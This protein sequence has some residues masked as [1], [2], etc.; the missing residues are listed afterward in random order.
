M[1]LG[2][3]AVERD[4]ELIQK[5]QRRMQKNLIEPS[6]GYSRFELSDFESASKRYFLSAFTKKKAS[7]KVEWNKKE[8][9][10][11]EALNK[12]EILRPVGLKSHRTRHIPKISSLPCS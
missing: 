2:N 11:R 9:K 10:L 6:K 12:N 7:L 1:I 4:R 3:T 8:K 5:R